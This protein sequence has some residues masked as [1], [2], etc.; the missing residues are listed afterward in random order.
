M[1]SVQDEAEFGLDEDAN[2]ADSEYGSQSLEKDLE[3][4]DNARSPVPKDVESL[5]KV[6]HDNNLADSVVNGMS[7]NSHLE[8]KQDEEDAVDQGSRLALR[9]AYEKPSSA[10]GSLSTPDDT[11]SVQ[12]R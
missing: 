2:D 10:D 9:A 8:Y 6:A 11:P 4:G 12:V 3:N 7:L 1:S 5:G